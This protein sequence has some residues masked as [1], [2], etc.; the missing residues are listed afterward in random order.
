MVLSYVANVTDPLNLD[1]CLSERHPAKHVIISYEQSDK[2][3]V[4]QKEKAYRCRLEGIEKTGQSRDYIELAKQAIKRLVYMGNG[5]A[6]VEVLYCDDYD[7]LIVRVK[8]PVWG[9]DYGRLL[10][11]KHSESYKR[12]Y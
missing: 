10:I 1:I 3:G 11:S 2:P 9:T 6:E 4:L 7:R 12:Y 8:D 5:W